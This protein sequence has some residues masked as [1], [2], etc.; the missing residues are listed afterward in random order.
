MLVYSLI[1]DLLIMITIR[2]MVFSATVRR[3]ASYRFS[4]SNRWGTFW[5]VAGRWNIS[6]ESFMDGSFFDLL[7]LRASY[8]TTGNQ[9]IQ[10]VGGQFA[11]FVAAD[12]TRNLFVTGGQY[13][14][15]NGLSF[16]QIGNNDL[17][18]ETIV[19]LNVG[20][21]FAAFNNRLRGA[22]DFYKK[23]TEDLFI[24]TPISPALNG[25]VT[26]ISANVGELEN[27]GVDLELHYDLFRANEE[28]GLNLTLK[29]CW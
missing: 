26:G 1:S 22:V 13:G 25:G 7:K 2:N 12:L 9:D 16:G 20:L 14:G 28:G 21:D 23:N 17:K 6:S 8:G 15:V 10:T 4:E 3:D 11:P 5:S 18:W 19:Q 29:L 27:R 24:N